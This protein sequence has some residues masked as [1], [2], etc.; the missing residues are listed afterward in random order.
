MRQLLLSQYVNAKT[1]TENFI[2]NESDI[3]GLKESTEI[4]EGDFFEDIQLNLD[5]Y[6]WI[7]NLK[8]GPFPTKEKANKAALEL[9]KKLGS[10]RTIFPKK[11]SIFQKSKSNNKKSNKANFSWIIN[12]KLGVYN[13]KD[14][15]QQ[16][17]QE[18]K[19]IQKVPEN[20]FLTRESKDVKMLNLAENNA[21][22]IT[23][24]IF[25]SREAK[26]IKETQH[27]I[28][29]ATKSNSLNVRKKP[30][31]SSPVIA[32][33]LKGSKVPHIKNNNPNNFNDR[34]F[35][36]EYSKGKFGWVSSSYTKKIID[37]GS[38]IS[39]Q[40]NLRTVKPK[41]SQTSE[42]RELKS[43]VALLQTE[44]NKI[45]SDKAK[46]IEA[47][48]QANSKAKEEKLASI[49][50]FESLKQESFKQ[51]KDLQQT[52][53][54]LRSELNLIKLDKAKA[55]KATK[56][57]KIRI[58]NERLANSKEFNTLKEK[59]S[60][61]IKQLQTTTASLRSELNILK[62]DK[63]KAIKA[64]KQANIKIKNERLANTKEFNDLKE[65]SLKQIK[66]L[67]QKTA[68]LRSELNLIKLDKA[69]AVE[70]INQAN[71]QVTEE[72]EAYSQDK[73]KLQEKISTLRVVLNKF[74]SDKEKT[75]QATNLANSKAKEEKIASIQKFNALKEKSSKQ[76]KDLEAA[77]VSLTTELDKTKSEKDKAIEATNQANSK[78][79]EEII[80][81]TKKLNTLKESSSK[82]IKDL[83]ATTVSL[84]T[85]LDKIKS[86]KD[87]AIKAATNQIITKAKEETIATIQKFNALK[88]ETSKQ[89]KD[90]KTITVSL[91]TELEKIKSEKDRA[92]EA[93]NQ[94]N[95]KANEERLS[96][97][98]E[99][100][101]LNE[102]SSRQIND[103]QKTIVSL[104]SEL[105]LIKVDKV[106]AIEATNL[107][108]SKAKDERLADANEKNTLQE[109]INTLRV[110][111]DKFKS[112]K[113][114]TTQTTIQANFKA[115]EEKIARIKEFNALKEKN[116]KQIK[117][118]QTTTASLGSELNLIKL[119]KA[120][121]I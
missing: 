113:E 30:S 73:N 59:S 13:S 107:A 74:K 121:A 20:V 19:A 93:T 91:T 39:Q 69:K 1:S 102:K 66:D 44:L 60:N 43:L 104:S 105:D 76:I 97:I 17:A 50:E 116:S 48:N 23:G 56:Q 80:A 103:L 32:S 15:A 25:I 61:Q 11:I 34:W 27:F 85:E 78:A 40:A 84:T 64:T 95:F 63:D 90:L 110:V 109:K 46:V 37:T 53:A 55:I 82:Q 22:D 21:P 42:F 115:K 12:L 65:K 106:R 112:N 119:D 87:K 36:I 24:Q 72:R 67:Q 77:T 47:S 41:D 54:S 79:E 31:S 114:K 2:V 99:F 94:A 96:S 118:L 14:K 71:S 28:L 8:N 5:K 89:I 9:Q 86:E 18:L 52:T 100:R 57:A 29:V 58:K 35:Y 92:V 120:N 81:S 6:V 51:L 88:D 117:Q 49:K 68:S 70:A 26:S 45:K 38:R 83:E 62:L 111:L 33:L 3:L 108:T 7:V 101:S 4:E 75:I 16:I 10:T 98:K